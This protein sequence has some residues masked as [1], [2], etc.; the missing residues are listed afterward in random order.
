MI[1]SIAISLTLAAFV[2][3]CFADESIIEFARVQK[4]TKLAGVV[5]DQAGAPL[6]EVAVEEM[7]EDWTAVLQRTDTDKEGRWSFAARPAPRIHN[8]RFIKPAFHQLR[9]R[10]SLTHRAAK[11]LDFVLPVS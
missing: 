3:T 10:V 5:R 6:P 8:I 1:R 9:I 4:A 2:A 11:R 7:S